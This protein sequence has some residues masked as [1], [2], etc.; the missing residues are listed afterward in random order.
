VGT[1]HAQEPPENTLSVTGTAECHPDRDGRWIASFTADAGSTDPANTWTMPLGWPDANTPLGIDENRTRIFTRD[2]N[3]ASYAMSTLATFTNGAT[4]SSSFTLF[5]PDGCNAPPPP[6]NSVAIDGTAVCVRDLDGRWS[7]T[8][9]ANADSTDPTN[10][11]DL[12]APWSNAGTP[13]SIDSNRLRTY[14]LDANVEDQAAGA[15]ATFA[16]GPTAVGNSP[17]VSRPT[18]CVLVNAG[19][20]N[21][22]AEC[23][24]TDSTVRLTFALS[25]TSPRDSNEYEVIATNQTWSPTAA[26]SVDTSISRTASIEVPDDADHTV[27]ATIDWLVGV[28]TVLDRVAY[29]ADDLDCAVPAGAAP[30]TTTPTAA[31]A[32][33]PP[34]AATPVAAAPDATSPAA[35][36]P[37][38]SLPETGTETTML[39]LAG[40]VLILAGLVALRATRRTAS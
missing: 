26:T 37:S 27:T 19:Q 15:T 28:N 38:V 29:T 36:D 7:A 22:T 3:V 2:A 32:A 14:V 24:A 10:T 25:G 17:L 16:N 33:A 9:T 5:R 6:D 40:T 12:P 4:A 39:M 31:P 34:V 8:F 30:V 18:D 11:W 35:I 23:A 1:S 21:V 13:I 20:I